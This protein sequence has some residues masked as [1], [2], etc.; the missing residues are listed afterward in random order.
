MISGMADPLTHLI[1]FNP[2]SSNG[3]G[4]KRLDA[5]K[6]QLESRGIRYDLEFTGA[7][8][9][10]LRLARENAYKYDVIVAAGGDGTINESI[11]GIMIAGKEDGGTMPALGV[12]CLG[13]GND[14]AYGADIPKSLEECCEVLERGRRKRIDIG[15]I[16]GGDAPEGRFF[17][18][19]I[20]IGFDTIVGI[21]ASKIKWAKGFLGYLL[22]ALKTIFLFDAP[23]LELVTD[24]GKST[25]RHLMVSAMNGRRMGGA[26]YMAPKSSNDDGL[27]DLCIAG[28]P[29]R[30]EIPGVLLQFMKG[31]QEG[32]RHITFDQTKKLEVVSAD[33]AIVMHA[34]G[35][36][37]CTEG[38]H[39]TVEL[40]PRA[41]E[42]VTA[43]E[44]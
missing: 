7:M 24:G 1:I 16:T 4:I 43:A 18:N 30:R 28:A 23:E 10:A 27:L 26:F 15:F 35:E 20:G 17:G 41:L 12:I 40:L 25:Q 39:I 2:N 9:D 42:V 14:F 3:T 44:I 13:R 6:S 19:G 32:S 38:R 22:G 31:T 36:T 21:E 8:G 29:K 37:I 5:V 11:N 33:G 34:D